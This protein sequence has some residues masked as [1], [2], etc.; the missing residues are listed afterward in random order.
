MRWRFLRL[1]WKSTSFLVG[2]K[3]T[4]WSVIFFLASGTKRNRPTRKLVDFQASLRNLQRIRL[5]RIQYEFDQAFVNGHLAANCRQR[6]GRAPEEYHFP[7]ALR[8]FGGTHPEIRM[9]ELV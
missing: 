8:K 9:I 5:F 2:R 1:A 3:S 7:P 6:H 4:G